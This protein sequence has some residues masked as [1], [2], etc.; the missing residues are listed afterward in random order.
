MRV[1]SRHLVAGCDLTTG[2]LT[3]LVPAAAATGTVVTLQK[4]MDLKQ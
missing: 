1:L 3:A 4:T 2:D